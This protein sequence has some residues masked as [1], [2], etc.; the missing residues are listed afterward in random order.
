MSA[1]TLSL[2]G[3]G[4]PGALHPVR[5]IASL[6]PVLRSISPSILAPTALLCCMSCVRK[7]SLRMSQSLI[8]AECPHTYPIAPSPEDD[9]VAVLLRRVDGWFALY[10][11]AHFRSFPSL[12]QWQ[13]SRGQD[14]RE[15]PEQRSNRNP[16]VRLACI[17]CGHRWQNRFY[18]CPMG[19]APLWT[20]S[21]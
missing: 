19:P 4:L 6:S 18:S 14:W 17:Q 15:V 7:W 2:K 16:E 11:N 13:E 8:S 12:R 5:A 21:L 10:L 9:S 1:C 20:V 3:S